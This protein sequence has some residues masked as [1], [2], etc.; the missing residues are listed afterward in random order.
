MK[1]L[2]P[3]DVMTIYRLRRKLFTRRLRVQLAKVFSISP[4]TIDDITSGRTWRKLTQAQKPK[5]AQLEL[6]ASH[7]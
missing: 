7:S 5:T 6:F 4:S 3:D 2:S 1:K